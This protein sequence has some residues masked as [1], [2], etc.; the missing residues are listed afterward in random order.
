MT[1]EDYKKHL[2]SLGIKIEKKN[3]ASIKEAF[4]KIGNEKFEEKKAELE[5]EIKRLEALKKDANVKTEPDAEDKETILALK[6][7]LESLKDL[8][9]EMKKDRDAALEAQKEKLQK[10][11]EKKIAKLKEQGIKEG[12]LTEAS[13][14]EKWKAIAEK[15]IDQFE[16]ILSGLAVDPHAKKTGDNNKDGDEGGTTPYRGPLSGANPVML[17]AM[18]KMAEQLN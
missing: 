16:V 17:E 7:E 4:E 14:E 1:F 6:A 18:D 9:S 2:E 3:E 15:D 11:A 10:E 8:L 12:K 13:W 5:T